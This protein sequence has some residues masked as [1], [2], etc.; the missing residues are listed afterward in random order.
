MITICMAIYNGEKY[1]SQQISSILPQL[2]DKDEII[3]SDDGSKD[4]S[5]EIIKSFSDSRIK[6]VY[7]EKRHG[8]IG[9]FENALLHAKGDYV[10]LCDQDD[11]WMPNKVQVVSA[12]LNDCDLVIHN[13]ELID[14]EGKQLGRNYYSTMHNDEGF[15]KN[16]FYP[17]YLGCCMAFKKKILNECLPFPNYRRGHDYWIGCIASTN[18]NVKFIPDKLI[19]YRRHGNNVTP[20]SEKS[21][22]SVFIK[23]YKRIDMLCSVIGRKLKWI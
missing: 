15:W 11:V 10:F 21:N 14:A 13:A 16:L 4:K 17:R 5:L 9:N 3:I 7:N 20:S 19:F 23:I 6:I 1:L 2:D 12:A 18:H 22:R 8:F